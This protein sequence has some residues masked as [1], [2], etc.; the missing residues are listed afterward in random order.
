M[1]DLDALQEILAEAR[2]AFWATGLTSRKPWS[3][4][5]YDRARRLDTAL[6]SA[7]ANLIHLKAALGRET[8]ADVLRARL[9]ELEGAA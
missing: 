6:R 1:S 8:E 9:A 3:G 4:E 2:R 7:D 5:V